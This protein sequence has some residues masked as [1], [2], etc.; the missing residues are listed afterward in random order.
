MVSMMDFSS[1]FDVFS[2]RPQP[3]VKASKSLTVEFRYRVLR[4]CTTT[5]P[6]RSFGYAL[7]RSTDT[8]FW[9]EM[10]EKLS[11]LHGRGR[12][13]KITTGSLSED[14]VAFLEDCDDSHFLDFIELIFKWQGLWDSN[15]SPHELLKNVNEFLGV[16]DLPYHL[17][18]FVFSRPESPKSGLP[19]GVGIFP[20]LGQVTAYPRIIRR[21]SEVLHETVMEPTLTLLAQPA[22]TSANKEFLEALT[23]YR[24]GDY[25]DCVAKCGSAFESVMKVICDRKKWSYKQTDTAEPLLNTIFENAGTDSFFKQPVM[26]V[27]TMRNRLS[28]A[29]GAGAQQRSIPKHRAQY[30]VNATASAILFLVEEANL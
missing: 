16:D 21:D 27:A 2:K 20:S 30:A 10:H 18:E 15:T 26:L 23:D 24:N 28:S 13:A 14:A 6:G 25:G 12:L 19:P 29:H 22:F 7:S 8:L 5:F 11:Y 3:P 17:T 4:L 9:V 1:I